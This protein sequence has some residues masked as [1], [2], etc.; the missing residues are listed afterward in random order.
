MLLID[1]LPFATAPAGQDESTVEQV[2][3]TLY[4][5]LA[6]GIG[7]IGPVDGVKA[8]DA[9]KAAVLVGLRYPERQL[10]RMTRIDNERQRRKELV[11][12]LPSYREPVRLADGS[13]LDRPSTAVPDT[14]GE[15]RLPWHLRWYEVIDDLGAKDNSAPAYNINQEA[16]A[17]IDLD[18]QED[19]R[20]E[21]K[22]GDRS[23]DQG[24]VNAEPE[25]RLVRE[26]REQQSSESGVARGRLPASSAM[27]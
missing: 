6:K 7:S 12:D 10:S 9:P 1:A 26:R 27:R 24:G 3:R 2:L 25:S 20:V 4:P 13:D 17:R 23:R 8:R 15:D 14:N 21:G 18:P 16:L 22:K 5:A 19:L 11:E